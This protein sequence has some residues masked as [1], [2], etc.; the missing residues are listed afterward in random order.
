M[1]VEGLPSITGDA[2]GA[3]AGGV[4]LL[5]EISSATPSLSTWKLNSP[6]AMSKPPVTAETAPAV[7]EV[8]SMMIAA[9][10]RSAALGD[11]MSMMI[12]PT[13]STSVSDGLVSMKA[14]TAMPTA[15][16][17]AESMSILL[18]VS[19]LMVSGSMSNGDAKSTAMADDEPSNLV[20]AVRLVAVDEGAGESVDPD[21][22]VPT[23]GAN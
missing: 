3:A 7:P 22:I 19:K 21:P 23:V 13:M 14:G 9:G 2:L 1:A 18:L 5:M 12:D 4:E 8:G 15:V 6:K 11:A 20:D 16:L 17:M 10:V